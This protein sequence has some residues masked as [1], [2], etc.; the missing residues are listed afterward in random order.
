M[1][2]SVT[3]R[4]NQGQE[5]STT[6]RAGEPTVVGRN[7]NATIRLNS[8]QVSREHVVFFAFPSKLRVE[9]RSTNGT[10]VAGNLVHRSSV[11][12]AYGSTIQL[13][14]FTIRIDL[15]QP[16]PQPLPVNGLSHGP[17]PDPVIQT[18]PPPPAPAPTVSVK[19]AKDADAELR[20]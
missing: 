4:T 8:D 2:A 5:W 19:S 14:E 15:L 11:D 3:V 16:H 1:L 13:G 17:L 7:P 20:R 12:A 10:I 6:V 18:K 9:D